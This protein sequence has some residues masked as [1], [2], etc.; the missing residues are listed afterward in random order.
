MHAQR[1]V[2]HLSMKDGKGLFVS[3][4]TDFRTDPPEHEVMTSPDG[5]TWTVKDV[6]PIDISEVD[7]ECTPCSMNP[8]VPTWSDQTGLNNYM[9]LKKNHEAGDKCLTCGHP[10]TERHRPSPL[11]T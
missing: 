2:K 3:V 4:K 8:V 11:V 5:V 1:R 6:P 7:L 9:I 10:W